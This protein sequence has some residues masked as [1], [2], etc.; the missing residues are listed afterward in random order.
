MPGTLETIAAAL[1]G[2]GAGGAGGVW[3]IPRVRS[4]N[5]HQDAESAKALAQAYALFTDDLREEL[6]SV[7]HENALLRDR[8]S[9]LEA[10]LSILLAKP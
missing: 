8:I 5:R 2:A 7:R 6:K 10:Q 1:L 9:K 3:G 4:Q